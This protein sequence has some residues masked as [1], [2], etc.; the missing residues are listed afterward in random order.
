MLL[1][2]FENDNLQ[3]FLIYLHGPVIYF[4]KQAYYEAIS[5]G[6]E[7]ILFWVPTYSDIP[8]NEAAD[9]VAKQAVLD[10][11]SPAFRDSLRR[12][13]DRVASMLA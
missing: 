7:I 4:I 3:K 2:E 6:R 13:L 10:G 1:T 5:K 12:F 11:Y 8:G 9:L